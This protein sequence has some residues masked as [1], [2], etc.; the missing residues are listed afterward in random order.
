MTSVERIIEYSNIKGEIL[1]EEINEIKKDKN[2][3]NEGKIEFENVSYAYDDTLPNVLH[4][5]TL[6]INSKEK[7]G[8][9]GRLNFKGSKLIE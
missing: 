1:K 5:L 7:I 8:I 6:K 3:P 2:W 9:I 4:N